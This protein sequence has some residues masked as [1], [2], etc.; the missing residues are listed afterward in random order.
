M[1][2]IE[3][4]REEIK[5]HLPK[6]YDHYWYFLDRKDY[7]SL[8]A[9]L[10][11]FNIIRKESQIL[12]SGSNA[13]LQS[14]RDL[15]SNICFSLAAN[16]LANEIDVISLANYFRFRVRN[17]HTKLGVHNFYRFL[18]HCAFHLNELSFGRLVGS[19]PRGVSF[20]TLKSDQD[21][22]HNIQTKIISGRK[23][24]LQKAFYRLTNQGKEI[25]RKLR[26]VD[27]HRFPLGIDCIFYRFSRGNVEIRI[28][29]RKGRLITIGN[30]EADCYNFYGEPDFKF[31]EFKP[32]IKILGNNAKKIMQIFCEK[33]LIAFQK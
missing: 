9:S 33:E 5:S 28:D 1:T 21:I 3:K 19:N 10:K 14:Y 11:K 15:V 23:V 2:D 7:Y 12:L 25:L 31:S 18:D 17:P 16:K 26:D 20:G 4:N 30:P 8:N 13:L 6:L 29:D 22:P 24:L 27:E 32:I